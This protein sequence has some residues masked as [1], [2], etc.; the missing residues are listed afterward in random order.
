MTNLGT[1]RRYQVSYL[2]VEDENKLR[3]PVKVPGSQCDEPVDCQLEKVQKVGA[4][5]PT[6]SE[7][8][9]SP[10]NGKKFKESD[11]SI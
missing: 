2:S 4:L 7:S 11:L 3:D 6:V 1:L 8:G 5:F 9:T 10:T